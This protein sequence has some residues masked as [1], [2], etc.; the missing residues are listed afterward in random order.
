MRVHVVADD[1]VTHL[2][3]TYR[4]CRSCAALTSDNTQLNGAAA[5]AVLASQVL[6]AQLLIVADGELRPLRQ[7]GS[8]NQ[9]GKMGERGGLGRDPAVAPGREVTYEPNEYGTHIRVSN[10]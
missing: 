8:L 5:D 3:G 7:S 1:T 9:T 10:E 2:C 4:Q 6:E